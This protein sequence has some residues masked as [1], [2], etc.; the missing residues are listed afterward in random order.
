MLHPLGPAESVLVLDVSSSTIAAEHTLVPQP[1]SANNIFLEHG[2]TEPGPRIVE[3]EEAKFQ[4]C[5]HPWMRTTIN[6]REREHHK[7]Q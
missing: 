2:E 5:I 1:P 4:C 7:H 3:D 6:P